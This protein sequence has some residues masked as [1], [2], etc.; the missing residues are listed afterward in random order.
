LFKLV[1]QL[2]LFEPNQL[3]G[4]R[5]GI[6]EDRLRVHAGDV[7]RCRPVDAWLSRKILTGF[8]LGKMFGGGSKDSPLIKPN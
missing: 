3:A 2:V 1:I 8:T 5:I 6:L 4:P 7:A